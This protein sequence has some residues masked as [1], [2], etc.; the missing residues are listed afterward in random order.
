ME[1]SKIIIHELIK[2]SESNEVELILSEE[3][4]P[5]NVESTALVTALSDSYKSDRI[6]YAVFDNSEGKYFQK[7]LQNIGP[8]SEVM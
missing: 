6:L 4:I 3:L 5:N 8:L 1:L 2:E 7:S